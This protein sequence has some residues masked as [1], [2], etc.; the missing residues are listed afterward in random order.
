MSRFVLV[1][2]RERIFEI[3]ESERL[4]KEREDAFTNMVIYGT[5]M[6]EVR[7]SDIQVQIYHPKLP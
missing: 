7:Q 4:R 2:V 6:V 5:G 1:K 3:V